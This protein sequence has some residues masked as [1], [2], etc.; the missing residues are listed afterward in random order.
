MPTL[1]Q[2]M[3][4]IAEKVTMRPTQIGSE[5]I[6]KELTDLLDHAETS[7]VIGVKSYC[8]KQV[9]IKIRLAF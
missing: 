2:R 5:N 1:T 3:S 7:G 4:G 9:L 6:T 8:L